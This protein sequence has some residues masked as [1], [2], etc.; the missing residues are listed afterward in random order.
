MGVSNL[1]QN[2]SFVYLRFVW[3]IYYLKSG[4]VLLGVPFLLLLCLVCC[5]R[6]N[7]M[8]AWC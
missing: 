6:F 3:V 8:V 2:H 4:S 7:C 1:S 5:Q